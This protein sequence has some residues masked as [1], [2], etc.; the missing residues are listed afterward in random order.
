MQVVRAWR[1]RIEHAILLQMVFFWGVLMRAV[2]L[3]GVAL[4][5]FGCAPAD[6]PS[7][8]M[9]QRPPVKAVDCRR[10]ASIETDPNASHQAVEMALESFSLHCLGISP[11]AQLMQ[12]K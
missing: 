12:S 11:D 8:S 2:A 9:Q 3:I 10:L 7:S 1:R 5:L 4:C 6:A